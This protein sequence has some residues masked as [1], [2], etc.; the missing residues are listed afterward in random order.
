MMF[1]WLLKQDWLCVHT[2]SFNH[3]PMLTIKTQRNLWHS[4]SVACWRQNHKT[5][6]QSTAYC[7]TTLQ[8]NPRV[9]KEWTLHNPD[10]LCPHTHFLI[11]IWLWMIF[12]DP[13]AIDICQHMN[14]TC[15]RRKW[16]KPGFV[17][18]LIS[19]TVSVVRMCHSLLERI[20]ISQVVLNSSKEERRV[21]WTS[22]LHSV[23]IH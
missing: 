17:F 13:K 20:S 2:P 10:F 7:S 6:Q 14:A 22:C 3:Y 8:L 9:F 5:C 23:Y 15:L 4:H 12:I 1:K 18:H 16:I 19:G 21:C 11:C